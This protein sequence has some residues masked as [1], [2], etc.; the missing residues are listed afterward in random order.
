V[1]RVRPLIGQPE[2][3]LG[4]KIEVRHVGPDVLC[5]VDGVDLGSFFLNQPAAIEGGKRYV[6]AVVRAE[7]E[8]QKQRDRDRK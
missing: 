1:T 4:R 2:M 6:D 7:Q 3:Y 8:K 5:E